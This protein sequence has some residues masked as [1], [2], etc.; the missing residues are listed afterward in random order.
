[1]PSD[2]EFLADNGIVYDAD[3]NE[4][5][6][7]NICTAL[8]FMKSREN[9]K[10]LGDSEE[11]PD[12]SRTAGYRAGAEKYLAKRRAVGD[13]VAAIGLENYAELKSIAL[14]VSTDDGS[15]RINGFYTEPIYPED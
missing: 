12:I 6:N 13:F 1:M 14:R 5:A 8:N 4:S 10:A 7:I 3:I 15:K 2:E 11:G 9:L